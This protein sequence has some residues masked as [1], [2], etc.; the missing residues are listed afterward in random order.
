M[1]I[2]YF[3]LCTCRFQDIIMICPVPVPVSWCRGHSKIFLLITVLLLRY[4]ATGWPG[5]WPLRPYLDFG[6][7]VPL[8]SAWGFIGVFG[9]FNLFFALSE[10]MQSL[11]LHYEQLRHPCQAWP[12]I[13]PWGPLILSS[14]ASIFNYLPSEYPGDYDGD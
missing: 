10:T 3:I 2:H 5:L 11:G 6:L 9:V 13:Q 7:L 4:S 14:E 1:H 12:H 8:P